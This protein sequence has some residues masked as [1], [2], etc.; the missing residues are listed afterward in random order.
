MKDHE[1][2]YMVAALG[3][4][5]LIQ[6][7][8]AARLS[9]AEHRLTKAQLDY[10]IAHAKTP[11]DHEKLAAYY[12]RQA[13]QADLMVAEHK[14][15]LAAYRENPLSHKPMKWPTPDG[16]CENLIRIYGEEAKQ[17]TALA[18]YHER[19]AKE[20]SKTTPQ[21]RSQY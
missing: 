16:Y 6:A 8:S 3:A 12:R 19:V 9:A 18:Q 5:L 1:R 17:F 4:I 20:S 2:R 21:K 7:L 13:Q 10:L 11:Q 15:M 14:K